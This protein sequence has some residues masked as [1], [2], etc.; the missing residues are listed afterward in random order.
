MAVM[1]QDMAD[2]TRNGAFKKTIDEKNAWTIFNAVHEGLPV[3]QEIVPAS[4][5]KYALERTSQ[6]FLELPTKVQ[7]DV[8]SLFIAKI[9]FQCTRGL[10]GLSDS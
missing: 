2:N 1:M 7:Q 3:A 8:I 5:D 9:G 4:L 6:K 10:S